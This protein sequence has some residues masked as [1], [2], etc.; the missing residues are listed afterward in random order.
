VNVLAGETLDPAR[1]PDTILR[2]TGP[3]WRVRPQ[4]GAVTIALRAPAERPFEQVALALDAASA[5]RLVGYE[6]AVGLAGR[7]DEEFQP[8]SFCRPAGPDSTVI[9]CRFLQQLRRSLRL[10]ITWRGDE[11]VTIT[12]VAVQ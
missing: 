7:A 12:G 6:I 11:P 3:G 9:A 4:R 1:G 5:R 10:V 8:V 2:G